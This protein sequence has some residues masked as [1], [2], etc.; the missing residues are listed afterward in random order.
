MPTGPGLW[1]GDS[2][3][4]PVVG[5]W[6]TWALDFPDQFR[7]EPP[8]DPDSPERA[9]EIAEIKEYQRDEDAASRVWAGIHFRSG[10]EA[11]LQ[12]GRDVG[13]AVIA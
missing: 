6:K 2:G 13:Q 1:T 11:G 8:S 3:N 9:A 12:L 4:V 10:V 7:P 5:T